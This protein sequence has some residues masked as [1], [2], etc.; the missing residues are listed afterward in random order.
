MLKKLLILAA[1]LAPV[2]ALAGDKKP[3]LDIQ[4]SEI[5]WVAPFG[6]KGPQLGFV[7]GKYGDKNPAS[8]FVK[9]AA[10]GDSGW[11]THAEEY[12]AVVLS[13]TFTEQQAGD[14]KEIELPPGTYFIQPAK[15]VHRN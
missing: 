5:S 10:G 12:H 14:G 7:E 15:V 1:C 4:Q 3:K 8:F 9:F 11:H 2:V 13:G 6:A